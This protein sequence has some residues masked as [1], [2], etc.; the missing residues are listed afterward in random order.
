M[1]PSTH[2]GTTNS[3]ACMYVSPPL[4]KEEGEVGA[5]VRSCWEAVAT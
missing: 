1:L 2:K 3:T 5:A 4:G